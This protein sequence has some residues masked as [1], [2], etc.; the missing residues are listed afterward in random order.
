MTP[1]AFRAALGRFATGITV[2]T[3][4]VEGVDHAMTA[5]ALA[6]VS[7]NPPLVLVCVAHRARFHEA[8][9]AAGTW[10][11]S[12][13]ADSDRGTAE[14]F[15]TRGRP[16][17]SQLAGFEHFRGPRTG[18][19]LLA[20]AIATVECRTSA[21]HDGGDHTI[22]VGEVLAAEVRR[23]TAKPLLHFRGGYHT[24]GPAV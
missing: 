3:T 7:L 15:A 22:M 9:S 1:E 8:I 12:I 23:Q 14:W 13:L 16:L 17:D 10:A 19:A 11:V 18:A 6:S 4:V 24:L 20:D 5:S 2:V 21:T